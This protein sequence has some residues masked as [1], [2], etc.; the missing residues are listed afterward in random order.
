MEATTE[1]PEARL[2]PLKAMKLQDEATLKTWLDQLGTGAAIR[3]YV[4]RVSPK[5]F[6]GVK[7]SGELMVLEGPFDSDE[8][9]QLH[10]GG[11]YKIAVHRVNKK[12]DYEH[13]QTRILELGGDP[14]LDGMLAMAGAKQRPQSGSASTGAADALAQTALGMV[15]DIT[16]AANA[17]ADR[18]ESARSAASAIDHG[19]L[20]RMQAPLLK[21]VEELHKDRRALEER[22]NTALNRKPE[23]SFQDEM[24]RNYQ[25]AEQTRLEAVRTRHDSEVRM[26][27]EGHRQD[28]ERLHATYKDQLHASERSHEREIEN[29]RRSHDALVQSMKQGG[30]VSLMS[31]RTSLETQVE[32][33]KQ[34][35]LRLEREILK[36]DQELVVLRAQK[37][38]T[39]VEAMGEL[40]Q[41]KEHMEDLGLMGGD[42]DADSTSPWE[43]VVGAVMQSP[44]AQSIG[45]RLASTQPM[46]PQQQQQAQ[47]QQAIQQMPVGQ[48]MTL[49]A[50]AG[51]YTIVK[52]PDGQVVRVATP[53][54]K[55]P[56]AKTARQKRHAAL[57][58]DPKEVARIVGFIETA[59]NNRTT[60]EMF[61]ASARVMLPAPVMQVLKL[62]GVD[63]FLNNVAQ[64]NENSPLATQDGLNWIRQVGRILIGRSAVK[65][66]PETD[67]ED[68]AEAEDAADDEEAS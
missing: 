65:P 32:G 54:R 67:A 21:Q 11:T 46:N 35:V 51:G 41:L 42:K 30:D 33:Q 5:Y 52:Q 17:R 26:L 6:Q 56:K 16:T 44:I 38:K 18:A 55:R 28:T 3:T 31:M 27:Q 40:S 19:L 62:K 25:A 9:A 58:L 49:P 10:G 60:P 53:T 4:H 23:T 24:L 29:L 15:K 50:W 68:D 66:E 59:I 22:L 43:R 39:P 37:V 2:S 8:I 63:W 20:E 57:K 13:L 45:Q 61:A 47:L 1:E 7:T 12:G 64:L 14:N 36:Q 34:N 48:P